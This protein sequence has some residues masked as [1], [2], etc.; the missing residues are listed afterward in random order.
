MSATCQLQGSFT[1]P[2]TINATVNVLAGRECSVRMGGKKIRFSFHQDGAE[3]SEGDNPR[4]FLDGAQCSC[5]NSCEVLPQKPAVEAV[6]GNEGIDVCAVAH[7]VS[8]R[9]SNGGRLL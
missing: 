3:A 7:M 4:A 1:M 8:L 9:R 5:T 2:F 6:R